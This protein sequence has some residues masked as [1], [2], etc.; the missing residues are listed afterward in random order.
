MVV[1]RR[2]QNYTGTGSAIATLMEST[3]SATVMHSNN[4][5]IASEAATGWVSRYDA[6]GA[7]G[8]LLKPAAPGDRIMAVILT[9]RGRIT[10]NTWESRCVRRQYC[11]GEWAE[12]GI[13]AAETALMPAIQQF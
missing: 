13:S 2:R 1:R 12:D 8:L 6:T 4:P 9:M 5:P 3:A 11:G 7:L 10:R